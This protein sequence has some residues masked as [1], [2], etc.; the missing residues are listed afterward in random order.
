MTGF[1]VLGTRAFYRPAGEM[2]FE[3]GVERI[4]AA[5]TRTREL[6]LGDILVNTTQVASLDPPGVFERYAM[7]T[8]WVRS[9]GKS[10]R[11]AIVARP[12]F[13]DHQRIG[14]LI[15]QNRGLSTEVFPDEPAALSWLEARRARTRGARW[16][17]GGRV[18]GY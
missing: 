9:A 16:P 3:Q 10:L 15:A 12:A 5:L 1:E 13:I 7:M 8:R 14:V 6:E 18:A 11:V 2:T 17:A 4:A